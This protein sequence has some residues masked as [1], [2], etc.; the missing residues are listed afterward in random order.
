ML[1][2]GLVEQRGRGRSVR[3]YASDGLR[4]ALAQRGR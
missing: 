3:Y 4:T 2:A 1:D